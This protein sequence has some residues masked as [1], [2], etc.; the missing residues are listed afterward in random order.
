MHVY[1]YNLVSLATLYCG[2]SSI[3]NNIIITNT[4]SRKYWSFTVLYSKKDISDKII[5]RIG[6]RKI[7]DVIDVCLYV[8]EKE[9]LVFSYANGKQSI[10]DHLLGTCGKAVL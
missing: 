1:I 5:W 9:R 3:N 10:L 2:S 7:Y 8:S 6:R 4:L